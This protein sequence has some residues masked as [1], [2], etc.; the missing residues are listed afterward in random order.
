MA[1][2]MVKCSMTSRDSLR[3]DGVARAWRR[4]RSL[5]AL[6]SSSSNLVKSLKFI[7]TGSQ[8]VSTWLLWQPSN[9]IVCLSPLC[10][11]INKYDDDDDDECDRSESEMI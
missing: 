5:T 3:A 10:Y 11:S 2:R 9:C 1:N 7:D 6:S 4:F 8:S